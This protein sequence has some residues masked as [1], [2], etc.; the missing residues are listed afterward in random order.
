[1]AAPGSAALTLPSRS[2]APAVDALD[3]HS[4]HAPFV[5]VDA[6]LERT[7]GGATV[8]GR[9]VWDRD[10]ARA[11]PNFMVEGDLRLLAVSEKGHHPTLLDTARYDEIA[12]DP[13][14]EVHLRVDRKDADAIERG[15]RVVLTASQH[16]EISAGT[17][18]ERTYVTVDSLQK[19][20]SDQDRIGRRDCS[21]EAIEAGAQ[22]NECDLTGADL[23]RALVSERAAGTRMR[24]ADLTGADLRGADLTGLNVAGGRMNGAEAEEAVFDNVYLSGAEATHLQAEGAS[25]DRAEG[26]AGGNIFA[27]NLTDADF[28]GAELNGLSLNASDLDGADFRDSTWHSVEAETASFRGA[29][30]RGMEGPA[31]N[32][33]FADFADAK[34]GDTPFTEVDLAWAKLCHTDLPAG[35]VAELADR[36]CRTKVE[37]RPEPPAEPFITV[38]GSLKR[39]AGSATIKGTVEWSAAEIALGRSAGDIRAVAVDAK[40]GLPT[41]IGSKAIRAGLGPTTSFSLTVTGDDK[42]ALEALAPGNR[43]VLTAT[44]HEPLPERASQQIDGAYVTVDTLQP[45]PGRGRVGSRDCSDFLLSATQQPAGGYKFCDLV[46]AALT[47]AALSAGTGEVDMRDVDLTGAKLEGAEL[48]EAKFDGGALA[49]VDATGADF[50]SVTMI[51]ANAPRLT[52][53]KTRLSGARVRGTDLDGADFSGAVIAGGTFATSSLRKALFTKA[54]IA[55][56]DL[57]YTQL[58]GARLDGVNAKPAADDHS[59]LFLADLTDATLAGSK[60]PVDEEGEIPWQWATLCRTKLP[61]G[62]RESGDRDCPRPPS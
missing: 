9:V 27:A 44:Q 2:D 37:E 8:T 10:A 42:A 11:E 24:L 36:D 6:H 7:A 56:V 46:G 61:A 33:Y 18:T 38:K 41:V 48:D 59:S 17:R 51:A 16:G 31:P 58:T 4:A 13:T 50:D 5:V 1:V 29:D 12:T 3:A 32:V 14:Q 30:L 57:A 26:T 53:P 39:A 15:N 43:V 25:V 23:Q 35:I 22:L 49:G 62:A 34:L 28:H 20:G 60:W 52:M 40:T 47:R 21:G 55:S 19:F 45:G 54:T